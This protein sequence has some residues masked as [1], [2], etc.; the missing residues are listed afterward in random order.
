MDTPIIQLSFAL[1]EPALVTNATPPHTH[2][3]EN[4]KEQRHEVAHPDTKLISSKA[5][6]GTQT[7]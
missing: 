7:S 6:A 4:I 1:K 5:R 3:G 2:T